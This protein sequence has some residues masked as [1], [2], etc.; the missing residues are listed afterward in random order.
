FAGFDGGVPGEVARLEVFLELCQER[1]RHFAWPQLLFYHR[2]GNGGR[3]AIEPFAK[4][5][6]KQPAKRPAEI[7]ALFLGPERAQVAQ[8]LAYDLSNLTLSAQPWIVGKAFG[9][10]SPD[11][12]RNP[13][14]GWEALHSQKPRLF[15]QWRASLGESAHS[16]FDGK[17]ILGRRGIVSA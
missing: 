17:D 11:K 2:L 6:F 4:L 1:L 9:A 3:P 8:S 7:V 14:Q 13:R 12:R 10:A 5:L 15:Q 16:S